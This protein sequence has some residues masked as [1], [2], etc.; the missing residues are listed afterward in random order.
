MELHV[1]TVE[2]PREGMHVWE[3]RGQ[4]VSVIS[5]NFPSTASNVI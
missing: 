5:I 1:D 4:S 3:S 2:I